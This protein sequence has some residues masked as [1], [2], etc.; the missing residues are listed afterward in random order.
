MGSRLAVVIGCGCV[1]KCTGTM[2]V[3]VAI[4]LHCT[5]LLEG[6]V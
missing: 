6:E 2:R 3:E 5:Y 1:N 4:I